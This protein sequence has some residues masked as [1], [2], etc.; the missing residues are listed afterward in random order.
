MHVETNYVQSNTVELD[1]DSLRPS[2]RVLRP[3]DYTFLAELK[4]SIES[5]GLLQPIAVRECES[6]FEVVFGNHR[7]QACKAL[8]KKKIGVIITQLT[9]DEAFIARVSEN[10]L[11]NTFINP[12]E[13]AKGYKQLLRN[14]WTINM[15]GKKLGK[16]DSYVCERLALIDRLDRKIRD[17]FTSGYNYLT[18]THLELLSKLNP[19]QQRELAKLVER[20]RLGVRSLENIINGVPSPR[21]ITVEDRAGDSCVCIPNTFARAT[22]IVAGEEVRIQVRGRKLVLE[23]AKFPKRKTQGRQVHQRS[24]SGMLLSC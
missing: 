1:I 5:A 8:G 9:E 19:P 11:R 21:T 7:L 6:G 23:N 20:K 10:L 12:I 14:G 18:P 13:E 15:I 22:G 24:G 3:I 2:S 4:K 17:R 16:S